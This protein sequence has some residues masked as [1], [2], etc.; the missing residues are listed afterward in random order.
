MTEQTFNP[1]DIAV[2]GM[3]GRFPDADNVDALWHN[4]RSGHC[5]INT[6]T[7]DELAAAGVSEAQREHADYVKAAIPFAN[8]DQFDAEFFG[9]TPKEATQLDPQQRLFLQTCWHALEQAGLMEAGQFTGVFAGCGVPAYLLKHLLPQQQDN[10]ITSLLALTN[11]N[12]KDALATRI[13]YELDLTG[14]AVTVQTACS[15]SLVAVHMACRALQNYECDSALAG[16]VW[17]NLLDDQ[18]T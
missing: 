16:G 8:K 3:A 13:S 2:V 5:A 12:E 4:V 14:P 9:Y 1:L 7:D 17:L 6:L 15:T 11:G 18:A 10:D